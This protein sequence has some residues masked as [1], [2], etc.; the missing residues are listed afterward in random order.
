MNA[1]EVESD[2]RGIFLRALRTLLYNVCFEKY[3]LQTYSQLVY[4]PLSTERRREVPAIPGS[5]PKRQTE[6]EVDVIPTCNTS[7]T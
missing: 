6:A 2:L 7:P 1:S 3:L 5:I 4:R